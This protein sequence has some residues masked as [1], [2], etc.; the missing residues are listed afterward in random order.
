MFF[1]LPRL[2][3]RFRVTESPPRRRD[4]KET[5]VRLRRRS[6]IWALRGAL[7][8][9]KS[10]SGHLGHHTKQFGL[11]SGPELPFSKQGVTERCSGKTVDPSMRGHVGGASSIV[12]SHFS[13]HYLILHPTHPPS[14]SPPRS[15]CSSPPRPLRLL[16]SSEPPVSKVD[17]S[18]A[19]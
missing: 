15:P 18:S 1:N 17:Q 6:L 14:S 10:A 19:P 12:L 16:P 4:P 5:R 2:R 3:S 11:P 8:G 7:R 9:V 13:L